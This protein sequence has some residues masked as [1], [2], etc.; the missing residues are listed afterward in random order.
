M[1]SRD[2]PLKGYFSMLHSISSAD[3]DF[4]QPKNIVS[5]RSSYWIV[6]RLVERREKKGTVEYMVQWKDYSP[7]EAS[8]EPEEGILPRCVELFNRPSPDV[9]IIQENVCS[10]RVAVERHLKSPSRS[11]VRLFFRGGCLSFL[12]YW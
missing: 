8:W 11:P 12:V 4:G 10:L 1:A 7:Y 5:R 2:G 6:G 9:A 3:A